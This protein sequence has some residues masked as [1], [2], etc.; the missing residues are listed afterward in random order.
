MKK[1]EKHTKNQNTS[2]NILASLQNV[3]TINDLKEMDFSGQPLT[4]Q[5]KTAIVNFDRYR[6]KVLKSSKSE[7]EFK[8]NYFRL[9]I[10]ANTKKYE[11]FL[12]NEYYL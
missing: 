12:K 8:N 5:Q 9:Q 11:E 2:K 4:P 10:L 1:E 7:T 6:L 3:I